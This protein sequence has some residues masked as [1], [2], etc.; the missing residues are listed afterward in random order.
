MKKNQK[1]NTPP[2]KKETQKQNQKS[3]LNT[4]QVIRTNNYP[5]IFIL[6]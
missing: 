1:K 5:M 6:V 3:K 2:P 4:F